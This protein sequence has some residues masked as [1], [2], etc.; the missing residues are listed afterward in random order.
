[1][2]YYLGRLYFDTAGVYGD[3]RALESAL[4]AIPK[5]RIVFGTDYPQEIRKPERAT[6]MLNALKKIGVAENGSEL[7]H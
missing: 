4:T 1:L 6:R 7:I 2:T 3:V 5:E